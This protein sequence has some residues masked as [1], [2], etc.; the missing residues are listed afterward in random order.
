MGRTGNVTRKD[1]EMSHLK[2][3]R[4]KAGLTQEKVRGILKNKYYITRSREEISG[5]ENRRRSP[6][7]NVIDC[8]ATIY[9][10]APAYLTEEI[11]WATWDDF[12]IDKARREYDYIRSRIVPFVT[13]FLRS[14]GISLEQNKELSTIEMISAA[15]LGR[16][17]EEKG[18]TRQAPV[19]LEGL[20][21]Q[22]T[23]HSAEGEL[24][25]KTIKGDM[26]VSNIYHAY[27]TMELL[28]NDFQSLIS[29]A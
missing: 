17:L 14:A 13:C 21:F 28:A 3:A 1:S 11:P 2:I 24:I 29:K 10:V 23:L 19:T 12:H 26:L 16:Q 18:Y 8:L 6:S 25:Q 7:K 9:N 5:W 22:V 27:R 4:E 15:I 20:R